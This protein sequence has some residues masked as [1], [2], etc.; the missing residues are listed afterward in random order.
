MPV[1]RESGSALWWLGSHSGMISRNGLGR[2]GSICWRRRGAV[3]LRP[4]RLKRGHSSRALALR[5]RPELAL[6][7]VNSGHLRRSE[8]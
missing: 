5:G 3:S 4:M 8:G 1:H 6:M 2:P 7:K